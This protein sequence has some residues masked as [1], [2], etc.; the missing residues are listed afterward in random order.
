MLGAGPG[1]EPGTTGGAHSY[2]LSEDQLAP[3]EHALSI[4]S[5]GAHTHLYDRPQHLHVPAWLGN[6]LGALIPWN[7][8]QSE[9]VPLHSSG[10]HSHTG[11]ALS[12]GTGALID[13][14][15]AFYELAFIMKL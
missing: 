10:N 2:V 4:E 8:T 9:R 11:T 7:I 14:R 5:G 12:V 1:E 15:P 13:N 3:H 6:P